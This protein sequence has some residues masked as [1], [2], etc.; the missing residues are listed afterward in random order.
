MKALKITYWITTA[1]VG[2]QFLMASIMYLTMNEQITAGFALLGMPV[3]FITL[4]GTAK[5]LGGIGIVL[6]TP[7]RLKEWT[8]VGIAF[9]LLGAVW[10][11]IVTSTSFAGAFITLVLLA[12]SYVLRLKVYPNK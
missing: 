11:H 2:A 5:L 6:P 1:L 7:T 8:Y 10:A 4:L 3:W 9:I 12:A